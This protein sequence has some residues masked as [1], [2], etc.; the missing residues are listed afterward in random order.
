MGSYTAEKITDKVYWVGAIDWGVRDFH[1][2]LTSRGSTY[3]AFLVIDEKVTLI[4]TVKKPFEKEMLARISS[5]IA[6]EKIDY[7]I[8]NHSEMDHTGCLPSV[9]ELVKPEKVFASTMGKK[10]L[11]SHFFFDDDVITAVGSGDSISLGKSSITFVETRMLHWPDSMVSYLDTEKM[12]FSQD[13]FG[14]HLAS[15]ERYDDQLPSQVLLEESEKYYANILLPFSP[16]VTGLIKKLAELNLD[17]Q[18]LC[19]DHGPIWRSDIGGILQRWEK[20]ALQKCSLKAV[21]MYDT[22]WKST[23]YLAD[24]ICDGLQSQGI[25]VRVMSLDSSHRSDVA[26]AVLDAGALIVGSPTINGQMF[27]RMADVLTYLKGL[28]P[29]NLIGGVFGSYG[30]SGEAVRDVEQYLSDM[31]IPLAVPSLNVNYVPGEDDL[32]KARE[33][34]IAVGRELKEKCGE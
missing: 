31:K 34:G 16:M 32:L 8:S 28:K 14:M 18:L 3:N 29:K 21:V 15:T 13:G 22:M 1:G 30:W 4:D 25:S 33:L 17:I 23:G 12:M 26:T 10:A 11:A 27:P 6:P 5:V 9:I 19:P 20:W 2:Y 24:A 7:I